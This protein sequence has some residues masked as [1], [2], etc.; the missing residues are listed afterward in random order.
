MEPQPLRWC[1][2][3]F[4]D[5]RHFGIGPLVPE[6]GKNAPYS[7][8]GLS[9]VGNASFGGSGCFRISLCLL[10]PIMPSVLSAASLHA[11]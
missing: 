5:Y 1:R 9:S 6:E 2:K 7:H 4:L 11:L 3:L 10:L 8:A